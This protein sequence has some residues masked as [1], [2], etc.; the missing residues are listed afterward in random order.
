MELAEFVHPIANVFHV[1]TLIFNLVVHLGQVVAIK[2]A[3]EFGLLRDGK[4][5]NAVVVERGQFHQ[6]LIAVFHQHELLSGTLGN[7]FAEVEIQKT[8]V[9]AEAGEDIL[10]DEPGVGGIG[11][12]L[13]ASI[14]VH[15]LDV[16]RILDIVR[17][18]VEG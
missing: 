5:V 8:V 9:G 1:G 11:R 12:Q 16:I 15:Q 4:H 13:D 18:Q 17:V 6:C 2:F 3:V 14:T 10:A 7:L